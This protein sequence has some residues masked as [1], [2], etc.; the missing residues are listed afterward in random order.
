MLISLW[1]FFLEYLATV[2]YRVGELVVDG[3]LMGTSC[4]Q[5]VCFKHRYVLL[6]LWS[7]ANVMHLTA[8]LWRARAP[9]NLK[10]AISHPP[11]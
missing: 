4:T 5:G 3:S 2:S 11:G 8:G 1:Q 9:D 10:L 6:H 7:A